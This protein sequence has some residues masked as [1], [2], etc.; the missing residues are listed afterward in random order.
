RGK[1]FYVL[2]F[3]IHGTPCFVCGVLLVMLSIGYLNLRSQHALISAVRY[4]LRAGLSGNK[5][6]SDF[7]AR[8]TKSSLP[9][10]KAGVGTLA[11]LPKRSGAEYGGKH[12]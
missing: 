3:G 9:L 2:V 5:C 7:L 4:T 12:A 8:I 10:I 6:L 1:N 11:H